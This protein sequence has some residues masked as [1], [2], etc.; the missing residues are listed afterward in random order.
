MKVLVCGGRDYTDARGLQLALDVVWITCLVHGD[1][2]GAD[3][4][5]LAYAIERGIDYTSYRA[6]WHKHGKG[7]GPI[8]NQ[9]MLDR[10]PDISM[11]V[12]FPGGSGTEDMI[13]RCTR[14][15]IEVWRPYG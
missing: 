6:D 4:L 13:K 3:R 15:G 8:R 10:E 7:A 9:L 11:C 5:A 2:R 1:A 14:K 12:A